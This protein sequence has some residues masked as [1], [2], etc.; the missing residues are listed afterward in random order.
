MNTLLLTY[1]SERDLSAGHTGN[2]ARTVRFYSDFVGSE[3]ERFD[4]QTVNAFLSSIIATRSRETA[5]LYRR[6]IVTLW[7]YQAQR[8]LCEYPNTRRIKQIKSQLDPPRAFSLDE[9]ERLIE[10]AGELQGSYPWGKRSLY[11]Q[12]LVSGALACGLRRGDLFRLPRSVQDGKRFSIRENKT[13]LVYTRQLSRDAALR[14][15]KL[16]QQELAYPWRYT[17]TS[18]AKTWRSII[19]RAEMQGQFKWL[20]RSFVTYSGWRHVDPKISRRHYI[21]TRL[22]QENVPVVEIP[23]KASG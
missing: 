9:I 14:L 10:A 1:L 15:R 2:L 3:P 4:Y 19:K 12:A 13:G 23:A 22:I 6:G 21:D 20:R 18:F 8:G 16:P 11:W 17:R 5:K 7:N